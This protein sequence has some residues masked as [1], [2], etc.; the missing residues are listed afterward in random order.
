[1]A[2]N[3]RRMAAYSMMVAPSSLVLEGGMTR[4]LKVAHIL[5]VRLFT[6]GQLLGGGD[7]GG[8]PHH[9]GHTA[10]HLNGLLALPG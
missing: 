9:R 4:A 10:M 8:R 7:R 1:M 2:R 3:S 6:G 5:L